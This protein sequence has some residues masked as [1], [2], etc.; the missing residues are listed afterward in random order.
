[1][2]DPIP[3][4]MAPDTVLRLV[5]ELAADTARINF[6]QAL[7]KAQG[8][9]NLQHILRVLRD[10]RVSQGP[11]V[12]PHGNTCCELTR[13]VAG[14]QVWVVIAIEGSTPDARVLHVLHADEGV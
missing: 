6:Q 1:M 13:V 12:D 8:P 11:F 2:T 4:P 9:V 5:R 7:E 10:G 14:K 3:F